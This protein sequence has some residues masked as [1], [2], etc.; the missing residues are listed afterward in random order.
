MDVA[1]E[2]AAEELKEGLA[3]NWR[4]EDVAVWWVAWY[5]KAG[6]KRLGRVM[7]ELGRVAQGE[8]EEGLRAA[9]R[10]PRRRLPVERLTSVS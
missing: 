5:M 10:M 6:H 9:P 8:P 1:A 3:S 2:Q 4:A 7:L